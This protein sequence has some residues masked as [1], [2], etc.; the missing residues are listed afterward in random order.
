MKYSDE[1]PDRIRQAAAEK[2]TFGATGNELARLFGVSRST[3]TE[4]R[5]KYP[6]FNA[7]VIEVRDAVDDFI[8]SELLRNAIGGKYSE[9][10]ETYDEA[11]NLIGSKVVKKVKFG[12]VQAQRM[13][14]MNRRPDEWRDKQFELNLTNKVIVKAE[15]LTDDELADI[16]CGRGT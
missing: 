3:I 7:A 1:Y 6:A 8:E 12:D 2:N 14:L 5:N 16:A 4:W 10:Y 9:T 15:D 11:G 13:W